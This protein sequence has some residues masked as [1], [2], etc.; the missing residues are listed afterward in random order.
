MKWNEWNQTD[1]RSS[2][3]LSSVID[4]QWRLES[5]HGPLLTRDVIYINAYLFNKYYAYDDDKQFVF[6]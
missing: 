6:C 3:E 4:K 1:V 2:L 5:V